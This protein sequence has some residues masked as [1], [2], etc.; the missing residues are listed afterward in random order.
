MR[1][2]VTGALAFTLASLPSFAQEPAGYD[3]ALARYK[4]C[5]IRKPFQHHTEGR[6][7]LAQTRSLSGLTILLDDYTK[8]KEYPEYTRYV[9]GTLF[10]RHFDR[11]E[12]VEALTKLRQAFPKPMDTWMWMSTLRIQANHGGEPAVAA[13]AI[14]DKNALHRAAAIAAIGSSRSGNIKAVIVP[15][16]VQFPKKEKEADR[17]ALLGAMTGAFWENR[18][19]VNDAEYR[20]ALTAYIGL[21]ADEVGLSH[22]A[23]VQMARHLQE[24][25]KAPAM[26][27]NAEP[28]LEIL[29]RGEVKKP[30]VAGGTVVKARFF[31]VETDGERF[32]YVVDMSDSMCKEISP[33]AKPPTAPITGPKK[34]AKR[35]G[36]ILD[37]SDIPWDKIKT[38]WDLARENLRI[39][40]SRLTPDKYFSIVWFG[41]ESGTLESC[42]GM[43]K[44]TRG[45]IDRVIAELDSIQT[46]PVGKL[47]P[48]EKIVSPDGQLRG[49][50]NLHSGIRRGF[51]LAG[52]GMIEND[53]YVDPEALTEGCDTIYL[54]SDGAP[55][56]DDFYVLDKDYGEGNVVVDQE[57]GA[58]AARTPQLWYPG[59]YVDDQWLV[60]D[61]R[62]MN[63]LRRIK[64]HCIGLGEANKNLL[65]Q[66]ADIG[67]GSVFIV[68]EKKADGTGEADKAPGG[69]PRK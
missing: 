39:S 7:K 9:M 69:E 54:L 19:R 12:C 2:I 68:G 65:Q 43:I 13:V 64:I 6:E 33:S 21:L 55:T 46:K 30:P 62:R 38:R 22:T 11:A 17:M 29:Q 51:A 34:T 20:D 18:A 47:T 10:G 16:C 56:I 58:K 61:V 57:Y 8:V 50:T 28:Y 27:V 63:V 41:T 3:T 15:N 32:C 44:A 4:E 26:F 23:K 14:E 5:I 45:N 31:G 48:D 59:P 40:I 1:T 35:K 49:K 24:I 37:E 53:A 52:K 60:E 25:L 67:N 36:S 66:L 42:K